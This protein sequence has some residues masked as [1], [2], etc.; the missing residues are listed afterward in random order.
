MSAIFDAFGTLIKIGQGTH[1]Y[2]KILRLGIE[3]GRRPKSTDAEVLLTMPLDLRQA[4]DYFGIEVSP[5]IMRCLESNLQDELRSISAYPDGV[6][7]VKKLQ[8]VGIKVA[9]CSN[10][11]KPYASAIERLY[12]NLDGYVYSFSVGVVKPHMDIYRYAL[13]ILSASPT[14]TRM[15]GDSKRNDC[16]SPCELGI[17]G[18]YLDRNGSVDYNSLCRFA[19][20][21]LRA[22]RVRLC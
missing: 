6:A 21:I 11:A 22:E 15:I 1:P 5:N 16:D 19:E 12:P 10:L 7:A 17:K 2:R 3:Q 4:A 8:E 13:R 18:F 9:V 14:E 20:D